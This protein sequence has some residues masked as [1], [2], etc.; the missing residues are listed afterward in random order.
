MHPNSDAKKKPKG[1]C[2]VK[3]NRLLA[4]ITAALLFLA[5]MA[6]AT[7]HIAY[8]HQAEGIERYALSEMG[9]AE[10][11]EGLEVLYGLFSEGNP[12]ATVYVFRMPEGQ[13][14]LSISCLETGA[15]GS[16]EALAEQKERLTLQILLNLIYL[17][18]IYVV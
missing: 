1:D 11:P 5:P 7:D 13:A 2:P 6:H 15:E 10:V 12:E 17:E 9:G 4:L 16:T 8:F 18:E 3:H 14:L